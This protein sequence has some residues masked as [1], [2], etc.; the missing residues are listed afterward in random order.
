M[1][2]LT[3]EDK[4]KIKDIYSKG[5]QKRSLKYL[6]EVYY[7]K[8]AAVSDWRKELDFAQG[9]N[10]CAVRVLRYFQRRVKTF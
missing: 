8:C 3:K 2:G 10:N 9:C 1:D 6:L 7:K 5:E 4:K